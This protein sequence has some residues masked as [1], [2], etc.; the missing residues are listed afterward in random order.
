MGWKGDSRDKMLG[1]SSGTTGL[2]SWMSE[3]SPGK[4]NPTEKSHSELAPSKTLDTVLVS[5]RIRV[6]YFWGRA[7]GSCGQHMGTGR[8]GSRAAC[9]AITI[10]WEWGLAAPLSPGASSN[11]HTWSGICSRSPE[12]KLNGMERCITISDFVFGKKK[13]QRGLGCGA[14]PTVSICIS[15]ICCEIVP[16]WRLRDSGFCQRWDKQTPCNAHLLLM[17]WL[18]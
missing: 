18:T 17:V 5:V 15:V 12:I 6:S 7:C 14:F 1:S 3:Q 13:V 2:Q 10:A 4:G 11:D 16:A 9:S 8:L